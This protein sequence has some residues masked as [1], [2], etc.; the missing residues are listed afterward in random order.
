MLSP[1]LDDL[2]PGQRVLVACPPVEVLND[3]SPLF[4]VL[5]PQRC[6]ES[7]AAVEG[8]TRFRLDAYVPGYE[9]GFNPVDGYLFTKVSA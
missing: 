9:K 7:L 6:R 3:D 4:L 2:E 8:D 5:I 1:F